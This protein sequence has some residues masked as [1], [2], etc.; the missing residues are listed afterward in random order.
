MADL[1]MSVL[2]FFAYIND[3]FQAHL[4]AG[5]KRGPHKLQNN[6]GMLNLW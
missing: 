3:V 5:D 1:C 6:S 2:H 4:M